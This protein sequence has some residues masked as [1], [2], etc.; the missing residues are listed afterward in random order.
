MRAVIV[1]GGMGGLFSALS[2]HTRR[3]THGAFLRG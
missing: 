1:G 3:E 2:L